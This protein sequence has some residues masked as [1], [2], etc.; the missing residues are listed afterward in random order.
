MPECQNCQKHISD[1]FYR[2]FSDDNGEVNACPNCSAQ[3]GIAEVSMERRDE[4][5]SSKSDRSY[6]KSYSFA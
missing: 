5:K 4:E 1:D 2:V 6:A 3:A